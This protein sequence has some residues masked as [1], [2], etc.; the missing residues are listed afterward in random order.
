MHRPVS[1]LGYDHHSRHQQAMV[2]RLVLVEQCAQAR[3]TCRWLHE[4]YKDT[5]THLQRCTSAHSVI[6]AAIRFSGVLS[7]LPIVWT[8]PV[9]VKD[10]GRMVQGRQTAVPASTDSTGRRACRR[11]LGGQPHK[12][13]QP[14]GSVPT[15]VGTC[16]L[17]A[18]GAATWQYTQCSAR[19]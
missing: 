5:N 19:N 4:L 15:H 11:A 12:L 1:Q 13:W 9:V 3:Q 16:L 17:A 6:T 8:V 7:S 14:A 10:K 2:S 18:V